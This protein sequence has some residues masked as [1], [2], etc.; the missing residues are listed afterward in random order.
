ML[1]T[2]SARTVI[3]K[4]DTSGV[5]SWIVSLPFAPLGKS[6][7]VDSSEQNV[8]VGTELDPIVVLRISASTR[9]VNEQ[10]SL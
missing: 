7:A 8:F 2:S 6:L 1:V 9:A 3:R 10:N 5:E 4:T